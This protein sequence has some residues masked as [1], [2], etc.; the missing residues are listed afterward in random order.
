MAQLWGGRFTK[1]TDQLVYNFNASITFDKRFY[2]QDIR[3]SLAHVAMLAKQGI[4]TDAEKETIITGLQGI[5]D[6]VKSGNLNGR[7][8]R[9]DHRRI[10]W[11]SERCRIR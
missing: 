1:E 10:K 7:R 6:D 11:H 3:G 9:T 4:L 2:K 8:K 5:L